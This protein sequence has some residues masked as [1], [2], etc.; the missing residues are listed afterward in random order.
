MSDKIR[1]SDSGFMKWKEAI[2][3][4]VTGASFAYFLALFSGFEQ[5]KESDFLHF[6]TIC[7]AMSLAL[8]TAALLTLLNIKVREE[9]DSAARQVFTRYSWIGFVVSGPIAFVLGFEFLILHFSVAAGV[10]FLVVG[11]WA[12]WAMNTFEEQF[13]EKLKSEQRRD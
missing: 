5:L 9:T 10:V 13:L 3:T 1:F 6:A 11:A 2:L 8:S 12:G 7:M 4:A